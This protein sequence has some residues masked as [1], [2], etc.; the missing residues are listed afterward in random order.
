M[1]T[2]DKFHAHIYFDA[3]QHEFV[4]GLREQI[5]SRFKL[6]VGTVHTR[7][8]GPHSKSMFQVLFGAVEMPA[9]LA[10]LMQARNGLSILIHGDTGDDYTDHTKHTM[11]LGEPLP[12]KVEVFL[13]DDNNKSEAI[14][15]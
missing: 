4:L 2:I 5:E 8:I 10:W 15:A 3:D 11:W 13:Q 1:V 14:S 12:I 9:F 6:K 7:P